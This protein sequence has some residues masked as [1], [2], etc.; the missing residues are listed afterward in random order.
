[1]KLFEIKMW[2]LC[3]IL[4]P[5]GTNFFFKRPAGLINFPVLMWDVTLFYRGRLVIL[6]KR[7][8]SITHLFVSKT[9]WS[10][11]ESKWR[12]VRKKCDVIKEYPLKKKLLPIQ[13]RCFDVAEAVGIV[14][15][16]QKDVGC[17]ELVVLHPDDVTDLKKWG[18]YL[19][20]G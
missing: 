16:E 7:F 5:E 15:W 8:T 6:Q 12:K 20:Y 17:D 3:K 10:L 11:L 19:C 4:G 14:R 1:M 9:L 2:I 18:W 13:L